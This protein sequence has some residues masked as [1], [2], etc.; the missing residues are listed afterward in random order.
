MVSGTKK[1]GEFL[2]NRQ[3]LPF[4][5]NP[6]QSTNFICFSVSASKSNTGHLLSMSSRHH[7]ADSNISLLLK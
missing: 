2:C 1:D 3:A 4:S 5:R 6:P 7:Q